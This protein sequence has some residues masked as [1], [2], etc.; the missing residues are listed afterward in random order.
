MKARVR[1]V[2]MAIGMLVMPAAFAHGQGQA[3]DGIIARHGKVR[4]LVENQ[5]L[6][7]FQLDAGERAVF[8]RRAG[9]WARC[10]GPR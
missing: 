6:H 3:I 10:R 2:V 9:G 1:W 4:D 5:W 7:L 8:A